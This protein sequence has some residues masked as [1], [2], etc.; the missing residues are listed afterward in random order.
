MYIGKIRKNININRVQSLSDLANWH[1]DILSKDK[2][3][4]VFEDY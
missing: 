1:L 2:T 4:K 3:F